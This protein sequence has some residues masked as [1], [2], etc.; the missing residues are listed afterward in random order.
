[1]SRNNV[2]GPVTDQRPQDEF[3]LN[4]AADGVIVN[5]SSYRSNASRE[6]QDV[7]ALSALELVKIA[8]PLAQL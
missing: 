5:S 2:S 4:N 6:D 8:F 1:M 7:S 3:L